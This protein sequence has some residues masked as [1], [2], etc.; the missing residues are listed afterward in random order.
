M[1]SELNQLMAGRGLEAVV[2]LASH[3]YS[4]AL[5][6]LVGSVHITGGMAWKK[7]DDAPILIVNGMEIEEARASGLTCYT[8]SDFNYYELLAQ[9]NNDFM[10]ASVALWGVI[11]ERLNI[12][13]G[14][15]GIYGVGDHHHILA[16]TDLLREAYPHHQFVGESGMTIFD[17]A[18]LTKSADELAR[19]QSVAER[20]N[21]VMAMTW[22]FISQHHAVDETV[23]KA[24]N[25][26][27]TIGDVKRFVRRALLDHDLEDT[28]MIFAQGRDAGF[29][30]SRGQGDMPLKLGQTIVFDLFPRE[31]GGGYHHDMTRTWCIGYATPEVQEL[32][33]QVMTAF[34]MAIEAYGLGKS[35]HLMQETVQDYFEKLGHPTLRSNPNTQHG[36]THSLGH[37]MGLNIHE[38]PRISHAS[39]EDTFMIGNVV[40]IEPGLYYPEKGIGIRVEDSFYVT[41]TGELVSLTS[42][43]KD[44][45]LPINGV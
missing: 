7:R 45:V 44:L 42:F 11:L 16:L 3:D 18:A 17:Q 10:K 20:T 32:Y 13:S 40:T 43:R 24:D 35:T 4:A 41:E 38:R 30:H 27:L 15:I 21:A 28:G 6:Y 8:Y 31:L 12:A 36:Y 22:D 29:P 26:P 25:T 33:Q 1:K 14:K 9:H 23:M 37:G 34:D 19:I 5:D 2:V 39:Q